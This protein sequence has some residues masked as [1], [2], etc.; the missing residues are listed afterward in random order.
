MVRTARFLPHGRFRDMMEYSKK[1]LRMIDH[2]DRE[3]ISDLKTAISIFKE[4]GDNDSV[5]YCLNNLANHYL[6]NLCCPNLNES[7]KNTFFLHTS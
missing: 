3:A 7:I 4:V 1:D 2:Y 5:S 6:L